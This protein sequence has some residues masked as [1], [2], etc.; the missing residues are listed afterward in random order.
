MVAHSFGYGNLGSGRWMEG[1]FLSL[2]QICSLLGK[3]QFPAPSPT[4]TQT[5][6]LFAHSLLFGHTSGGRSEMDRGLYFGLQISFLYINKKTQ[7]Y[8]KMT[9]LAF[10]F[11]V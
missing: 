1:G 10:Y 3:G 4:Q 2:H 5:S 7:N 11:P 6:V 9:F 8:P